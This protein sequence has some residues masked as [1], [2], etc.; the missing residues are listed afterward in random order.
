MSLLYPNFALGTFPV[1]EISNHRIILYFTVTHMQGFVTLAAVLF[2]TCVTFWL[3][4]LSVKVA[5]TVLL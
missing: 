3:F 4:A 1:V 5:Q 2:L